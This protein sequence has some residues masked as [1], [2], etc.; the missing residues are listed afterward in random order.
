MER[1]RLLA[2]VDAIQ[3]LGAEK[4]G[5]R[6]WER[7]TRSGGDGSVEETEEGSQNESDAQYS[8]C[9]RETMSGSTRAQRVSDSL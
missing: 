7:H 3:M 2:P 4:D 8:K 6:R 9:S 1:N 5:E